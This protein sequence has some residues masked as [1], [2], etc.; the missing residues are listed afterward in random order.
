MKTNTKLMRKEFWYS[1]LTKVLE[2][3]SCPQLIVVPWNLFKF[4][5]EAP[6]VCLIYKE[7]DKTM[8]IVS[9]SYHRP[10]LK[11]LISKYLFNCA[12]WENK[13]ANKKLKPAHIQWVEPI[14]DRLICFSLDVVGPVPLPTRHKKY[15]ESVIDHFSRWIELVA[16]KNIK[17]HTIIDKVLIDL[18][19]RF[20]CLERIHTHRVPKFLSKSMKKF[21]KSLKIHCTM[22]R[23]LLFVPNPTGLLNFFHIFLRIVLSQQCNQ[24]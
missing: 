21:C 19:A 15:I 7:R 11:G 22:T 24:I 6:R 3:E 5:K 9:Q 10:W 23:G 20:G 12:L 4:I 13:K 17:T 18:I 16:V 1:Y 2:E 8:Y 14:S